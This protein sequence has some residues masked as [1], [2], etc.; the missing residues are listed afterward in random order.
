[1]QKTR[2]WINTNGQILSETRHITRSRPECDRIEWRLLYQNIIVMLQ[3]FWT[4]FKFS[5][6]CMEYLRVINK[7]RTYRL[8]FLYVAHLNVTCTYGLNS[9]PKTKVKKQQS[10]RRYIWIKQTDVIYIYNAT[11]SLNHGWKNISEIS[12]SVINVYN[13]FC[14]FKCLTHCMIIEYQGR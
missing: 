4:S 9:C 3:W 14:F 8:L 12:N 2:S 6:W 1:M 13:N 5:W 10:F 7:E 11:L